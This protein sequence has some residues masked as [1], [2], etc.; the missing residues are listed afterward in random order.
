M[1][2]V[3]SEGPVA[4]DGGEKNDAGTGDDAEG[5]GAG[6]Q[7]LAD[8]ALDIAARGGG[9]GDMQGETKDDAAPAAA[10]RPRKEVPMLASSR[11]WEGASFPYIA[12]PHVEGGAGGAG[13]PRR[14]MK[15]LMMGDSIAGKTSLIERFAPDEFEPTFITTIGIDYKTKCIEMGG[16]D[17]KALVWDTA[18]QERFREITTS[19]FRGA[20]MICVVYNRSNRES[21]EHARDWLDQVSRHAEEPPV[22]VCV[23]VCVSPLAAAPNG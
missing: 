8:D 10:A 20:D 18:G 7:A 23:C 19:Y 13:T 14:A 6:E 12:R 15:I 5:A 11:P 17:V 2:K 4:P 3:A 9:G 21:F 1:L 16:V 22:Y